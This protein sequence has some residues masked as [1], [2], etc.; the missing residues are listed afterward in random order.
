MM[1]SFAAVN[2]SLEDKAYD[3][4]EHTRE[5]Q[6]EAAFKCLEKALHFQKNSQFKESKKQYKELF[7]INVITNNLTLISPNIKTLKYLAYRNRGLLYYN[8]VRAE[9][10]ANNN[11]NKDDSSE[12]KEEFDSDKLEDLF[13]T[14]M[15]CV[16]DLIES[17]QH[18]EPDVLVINLLLALAEF[19]ENDRLKRFILDLELT[20]EDETAFNFE[21]VRLENPMYLR[22]VK[23]E[24]DL[25]AKI[26]VPTVPDSG[27]SELEGYEEM[28]I[29]LPDLTPLTP[30]K[31]FVSDRRDE[32]EESWTR[33]V[34]LDTFTW[35]SVTTSFLSILSKSKAKIRFK[36]PY[37]SKDFPLYK[38]SYKITKKNEKEILG[39][40][41]GHREEEEMADDDDDIVEVIPDAKNRSISEPDIITPSDDDG[42]QPAPTK[43][44]IAATATITANPN[45]RD[46][47]S[48]EEPQQQHRSSKRLRAEQEHGDLTTETLLRARRFLQC[49]NDNISQ[50]G[51]SAEYQVDANDLISKLINSHSSSPASQNY[52]S[53]FYNLLKN[54]D[55]KAT[56]VLFQASDSKSSEIRL[57]ELF[58]YNSSEAQQ[59]ENQLKL[60]DDLVR[61]YVLKVNKQNFH[62]NEAKTLFLETLLKR[63]EQDGVCLITDLVIKKELMDM[64]EVLLI[65]NEPIFFSLLSDY[66]SGSNDKEKITLESAS[67][68]VSL[69]EILCDMLLNM[70]DKL[71]RKEVP[72]KTLNDFKNGA[73]LFEN[74]IYKWRKIIEHSEI[75][76]LDTTLKFRYRWCLLLLFKS[77]ETSTE[78]LLVFKDLTNEFYDDFQRELATNDPEDPEDN[79]G[80]VIKLLNYKHIPSISLSMIT[81]QTERMNLVT[82]FDKVFIN[83]PERHSPESVNLME[84]ILL[85]PKSEGV[86]SSADML[87]EDQLNSMCL[88]VKSSPLLMRLKLWRY[89]FSGYL[90]NRDVSKYCQGLI[91]ILGLLSRELD[92]RE[93]EL[94]VDVDFLLMYLSY[95]GE[96]IQGFVKLLGTESVNW[97]ISDAGESADRLI[98]SLLHALIPLFMC[99]YIYEVNN[100]PVSDSNGEEGG[101]SS[102]EGA[103]FGTYRMTTRA[104]LKLRNTFISCWCCILVCFNSSLGQSASG[105]R[106]STVIESTCDFV[107]I[108]HEEIGS[109]HFCDAA[110]SHFLKLCHHFLNK[111]DNANLQSNFEFDNLQLV[112]CLYH[113]CIS[114]SAGEGSSQIAFT[115]R[116]HHTITSTALTKQS[117]IQF[118]EFFFSLLERKR[119]TLSSSALMKPDVKYGLEAIYK[120]IGK[121]KITDIDDAIDVSG[122]G[123][124]DSDFANPA[125]VHNH[126]TLKKYLEETSVDMPLSKQSLLGELNLSFKRLPKPDESSQAGINE[127]YER[128]IYFYQA[129]IG[130][131]YYVMRK[132]QAQSKVI[133][134]EFVIEMLKF[135]IITTSA[136]NSHRLETWILL[137]QSYGLLAENDMT[138][139]ADRL[140]T[141]DRKMIIAFNQRK[142]IL[143]YFM[144]LSLFLQDTAKANAHTDGALLDH[145]FSAL[146]I[147]L[148]R[149]LR[150]PMDGLVFLNL[151]NSVNR[152]IK[153]VETPNAPFSSSSSSNSKTPQVSPEISQ[154][155]LKLSLK[156]IKLAISQQS[157][158][159]SDHFVWVSYYYCAKIQHKLNTFPAQSI[160][161]SS[162]KACSLNPSGIEAHYQLCT[163]LY[164]YHR[165]GKLSKASTLKLLAQLPK[166]SIL[167]EVATTDIQ[168]LDIPQL[169]IAC[170]KRMI[171]VDKK[172]WHHRLRYRLSRI[173]YDLKN[174]SVAYTE[175]E[176]LLAMKQ[177]GSA[178]YAL[179][180]IWKTD[181]EPP[182]KH[183]IY[184]YQYAEHTIQMMD[185]LADIN[186][187]RIFIK[188]LRRFG[189]SMINLYDCWELACNV[190]CQLVKEILQIPINGYVDFQV[191]Q[192]A[193]TEFNSNVER[194]GK[195]AK[196]EPID[197]KVL[198]RLVLLTDMVEVKRLNNGFGPTSLVDDTVNCI[199]IKHYIDTTESRPSEFLPMPDPNKYI[200]N[201]T[202]LIIG[203]V[204]DE[205]VID[206]PVKLRLARKEI[207]ALGTAYIKG[208]ELKLKLLINGRGSNSALSGSSVSAGG[209]SGTGA[210]TG[211]G[212]S[213]AIN[214]DDY[215]IEV[216]DEVKKLHLKEH[217]DGNETEEEEELDEPLASTVKQRHPQETSNNSPEIRSANSTVP[218]TP[219]PKN[220]ETKVISS[221]S[222][223]ISTE[224]VN[225]PSTPTRATDDDEDMFHTPTASLNNIT[226]TPPVNPRSSTS[227]AAASPPPPPPDY[228]IIEID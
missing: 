179:I 198:P 108:I 146:P 211:S 181:F 186:G 206:P 183:F 49:I 39:K 176:P 13:D 219:L 121:P 172:K 118:S 38:L 189:S 153:V 135:D 200:T 116:D 104:F 156:L 139:T 164:K 150:R 47:P 132:K 71:K 98:T 115:P 207:I 159:D 62:F 110:N 130:L 212:T 93:T 54:W 210:G 45:K 63:N 109:L 19:F 88:Y 5:L 30:L 106:P 59:Q 125:I 105:M 152:K 32:L 82:V 158:S 91:H 182:G 226:E 73:V 167:Y 41:A 117:A 216:S 75:L 222:S 55:L 187:L 2:L 52:I 162:L 97:T 12:E 33:A 96:Y 23:Y 127:I 202:G 169:I 8:E 177:S 154:F 197:K 76:E 204:G 129:V 214:T 65:T 51:S 137:G 114:S 25:L 220:E 203:I 143:C 69:F 225:G 180:N 44:N 72:M 111:A 58:T 67:I 99:Y 113:I 1:S 165:S 215:A 60:N 4:E 68:Y 11:K 218:S 168:A 61:E 102:S 163:L 188:K 37:N 20:K 74:N 17:L 36:D 124:M 224:L 205:R 42:R 173:H 46:H 196:R 161:K 101:G 126:Y 192:M 184:N 21:V 155:I 151:Q 175:F 122:T 131:N 89:L 84:L 78:S 26:G 66:D 107:S 112:N 209:A 80:P 22:F 142:S 213:S 50:V 166:V 27:A 10:V 70:R 81:S 148:F 24:K 193:Y 18:N 92:Q 194:M 120:V 35:E 94:K 178:K 79:P 16:E 86:R 138:K 145:L 171:S 123:A 128:G 147:S 15:L 9:F 87:S 217:P 6:I 140:N 95:A 83:P 31:Q 160:I 57:E 53:T 28:K 3:A 149:C 174:F 64:I 195:L 185:K 221:I 14:L 190:F 144:A 134:L 170:L 7:K 56:E 141:M 228:E 85:G 100:P 29:Q 191:L 119:K 133:D 136:E 43:G 199:F 40:L 103:L 77:E 201:S 90:A 157:Q 223:Q 34:N 227:T 208:L 48:T